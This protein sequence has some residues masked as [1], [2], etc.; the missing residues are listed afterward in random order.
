[1]STLEIIMGSRRLKNWAN[2]SGHSLSQL[3]RDIGLSHPCNIF[4]YVNGTRVPAPELRTKI[5]RHTN[6]MVPVR[7]WAKP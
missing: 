6:G 1:M 4:R 2:R 7:A 3:A 5:S